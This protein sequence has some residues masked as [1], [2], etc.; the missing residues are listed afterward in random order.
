MIAFLS[1]ARMADQTLTAQWAKQIISTFS[2]GA[3]AWAS[4]LLYRN[5]N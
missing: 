1:L 5:K 3:F 2:Q 4:W